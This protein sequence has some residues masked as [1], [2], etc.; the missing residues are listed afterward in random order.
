DALPYPLPTH[1]LDNPTAGILVC[2]KTRT[3]LIKLQ[4]DFAERNIQKTYFALVSGKFEETLK[5]ETPI[6][7]K[8]SVT[9]AKPLYYYKIKSDF[10]TL[11]EAR[12]LT[13]KTHQIR[14]HLSNID[15]PIVGDKIYGRKETAFFENKNLYLFSGKI[16]FKHPV[17]KEKI[18]LA[19]ELPKRFRN[20]NNY[21]LP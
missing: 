19:I 17:N 13:G 18:E 20:L 4:R 16:S 8:P 21:R 14:I 1:R 6:D 7:D 15:F 3:S 12:P 10:F 9:L 5:I 11:V 2:A